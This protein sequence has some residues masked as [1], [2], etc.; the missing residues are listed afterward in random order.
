[1]TDVMS[2]REIIDATQ[3]A[4]LNAASSVV[5]VLENTANELSSHHHEP[6]YLSA[7]F[8]VAMSFVLAVSFLVRPVGKLL[9]K[10]LKKRALKIEQRIAEANKLKEEAQR[11]LADYERK[12][13]NAKKQAAA[14]LVKSE[15]E[16]EMIKKE[17]LAKL[18]IE[19]ERRSKEA[20]ERLKAAEDEAMR[21]I[22]D[23]TADL[24]M[25]LVKRILAN[26]L[27]DRALGQ[28]VDMAI[29]DLEKIA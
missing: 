5:S 17:S 18:E 24:T 1:M 3:D 20:K 10:M 23:K 16:I 12:A 9:V 26:N 8:W 25:T 28:M 13:R 7:E 11:L 14:I 27:D 15:R 4:V 21:D 6:F 2:N 29:E 19:M 22:A